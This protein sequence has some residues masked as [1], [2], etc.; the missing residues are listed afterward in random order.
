[1]LNAWTPADISAKKTQKQLIHSYGSIDAIIK[2][3]D[4][5]ELIS[6]VILSVENAIFKY[7]PD[8]TISILNLF[9][10]F[11]HVLNQYV[12]ILAF[13]KE[14]PLKVVHASNLVNAINTEIRMN[15]FMKLKL[16]MVPI[17]KMFR[18]VNLNIIKC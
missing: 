16:S 7:D 1:M 4:Y 13:G 6:D 12:S 10:L 15:N 17:G 5:Y 2:S 11:P 3:I 8:N 18:I 14:A 9:Y